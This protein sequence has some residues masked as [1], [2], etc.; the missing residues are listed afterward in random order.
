M[1]QPAE[2]LQNLGVVW[3][4]LQHPSVGTFCSFILKTMSDTLYSGGLDH[5]H[6]SAVHIHGLSGTIYPPP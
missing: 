6:L 3:V 2:L 4:S 5:L 1:M